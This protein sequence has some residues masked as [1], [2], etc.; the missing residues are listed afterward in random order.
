[1]AL[2]E[3]FT[4][5]QLKIP[6][7]KVS[8]RVE[9]KPILRELG[10]DPSFLASAKPFFE[11]LSPSPPSPPIALASLVHQCFLSIEENGTVAAAATVWVEEGFGW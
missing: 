5:G 11:M 7:F 9:A 6:K 2:V 4:V 1:M 3:W 10:L 8:I